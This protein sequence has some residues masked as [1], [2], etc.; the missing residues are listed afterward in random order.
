MGFLP[1]IHTKQS[2]II[3]S[4]GGKNSIQS[5]GTPSINWEDNP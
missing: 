3:S 2:F 1:F 4:P 5:N